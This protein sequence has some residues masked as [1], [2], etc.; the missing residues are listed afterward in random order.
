MLLIMASIFLQSTRRNRLVK[1]QS[2]L[3]SAIYDSLPDSI[4]SKDMNRTFTGFNHAFMKFI[5][6]PESEI[7]GKT[8]REVFPGQDEMTGVLDDCDTVVLTG[9]AIAKAEIWYTYPDH[10][11]RLFEIIRTPIIEGGKLAGLVGISR[12]ITELVEAKELAERN[13]RAKSDFL[14]HVSHEIRTPMN[15]IIGL[16]EL[17][18]RE[19]N[20]DTLLEYALV[21]KQA[22][23]N[24][25]ALINDIL[26]FS[27]IE[28]GRLKI[29]EGKYS[30]SSLVND[31][32][33]IIRM[34]L[35][36]S[37]ILFAVNIDSNLP[38]SLS[39][40]ELR[41]RQIMLNLLNNAV[42]Y[43]DEGFILLT[44][45]GE[46]LED[47]TVVN[48][49]IEVSDSGKG[50][51]QEDLATIF[52]EYTQSDLERNRYIEGT[53]LGLSIA[54]SIIHAMGGRIGVSSEY[55]KGSTFTVTAPQKILNPEKIALVDNPEE[56]SVLIFE[57]RNIYAGSIA[58]TINNL[59]AQYKMA[60]SEAELRTKPS[61]RN[62]GY[63]FIALEKIKKNKEA[64]LN[65]KKSSKIVLLTDFGETRA[66]RGLNLL[67]MPVQC[68]SIANIL[69]GECDNFSYT[70]NNEL[71]AR[72][73][74]PEARILVVD[75]IGTNLKVAEGLLLAY[76]MR[77]DTCRSGMAAIGAMKTNNYDLVLMDQKMP[78]MDGLETTKMI[79][80]SGGTL[81]II[82][83]TAN[84]V[85]GVK[86]MFLASGF[87]DYLAKPIDTIKLNAILE[88][89]IPKNKQIRTAN[90]FQNTYAPADAATADSITVEG[91][92]VKKGF[93]RTGGAM[94]LYLDT[95]A[96]F[97]ADAH[98]KI[99]EIEN[100]LKTGDLSLY[101]TYVHAL[102]SA[103]AN[104]GA[105]ELSETAKILE[106]AGNAGDNTAVTRQG[107]A[108]IAA[109]EALTARINGV[110]FLRRG[111]AA[112]QEA[113]DTALLK[114][115]LLEL[116]EAIKTMDA[117][118]ISRI[119]KNFRKLPPNAK[120][121]GMTREISDSILM[122]DYEEAVALINRL[123]AQVQ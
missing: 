90:P 119:S 108:F 109:L 84:A 105:T 92:D 6:R 116:R 20:I 71:V 33:S 98:E 117:D 60:S 52:G 93:L 47:S 74:A 57:Q 43:T 100:C 85:P 51:K 89:W 31:V 59:G 21:V 86:E 45:T 83:L 112:D 101:T 2:A 44:V 54:R 35:I 4:F 22:S 49:S 53:G 28:R 16:T 42:K 27:K 76:K 96:V 78:G 12:D 37:P 97:C 36:D 24:L 81:P 32:I 120:I 121:G 7:M 18:L 13:S 67:S 63:I 106:E 56:K 19:R 123:V 62:N 107:P 73:T 77:I 99:A 34:R 14:A 38:N 25:M 29:I 3:L 65:I 15:A 114:Q 48:L 80:A 55:G 9:G 75:D 41:L 17:A 68:V 50:V 58:Y 26:D 1:K 5:G 40:D 61:I 82:A 11:R 46:I 30:L 66:Q 64:I 69:N 10:S 103:A 118:T 110:L 39:G 104:I 113:F 102:K 70:D 111:N 79:R 94:E 91:L 23:S 88:K 8:S 95:L 122:G 72:F 87:N 115:E